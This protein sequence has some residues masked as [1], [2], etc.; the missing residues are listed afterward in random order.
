MNIFISLGSELC[1][2]IVVILR[3][4]C[5]YSVSTRRGMK[6]T[7]IVLQR[8]QDKGQQVF[9]QMVDYIMSMIQR[10]LRRSYV[11]DN[12]RMQYT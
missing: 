7:S 1:C 2:F 5:S 12:R 11:Q 3:M 6:K 9:E 10:S 4:S 8:S